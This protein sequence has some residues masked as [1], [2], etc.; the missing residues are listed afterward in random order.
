MNIKSLKKSFLNWL[1]QLLTL[2][3]YVLIVVIAFRLFV[4][5]STY[6]LTKFPE[7]SATNEYLT[8]IRQLTTDRNLRIYKELID[9][10]IPSVRD[11]HIQ[12]KDRSTYS[13]VIITDFYKLKQN[14]KEPTGKYIPYYCRPDSVRFPTKYKFKIKPIGTINLSNSKKQ[15]SAYF[16]KYSCDLSHYSFNDENGIKR[17]VTIDFKSQVFSVTSDYTHCFRFLGCYNEPA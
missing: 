1:F 11:E 13:T 15:L 8:E 10:S 14:Y 4:W 6:L 2:F 17:Y 5:I 12:E 3:K 7:I 9:T 16:N